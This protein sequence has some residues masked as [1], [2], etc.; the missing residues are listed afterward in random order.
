MR[1]SV[2]DIEAYRWYR[3]LEDMPLD[4]LLRQLRRQEEPTINMLAGTA[5]H[6][7]LEDSEPGELDDAESQGFHFQFDL[8]AE[9]R[10]PTARELKAEGEITVNGIPVTLVGK[11]D[12]IH[13]C[14]V[15]DHKLTGRFDAERYANSFQ[16]RAYLYLLDCQWFT[17]N[18]FTGRPERDSNT[19]WRVTAFDALDFYRYPGM[20]DDVLRELGQFVDFACEYL[21]ER[22]AA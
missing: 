8:D 20:E 1:C 2:T 18:V 11:V 15:Y 12:A 10:L 6:Q 9:L 7:L 17:Y 14:R 22:L 16:W 3:A 5:F 21:P 13:G 4:K 19:H